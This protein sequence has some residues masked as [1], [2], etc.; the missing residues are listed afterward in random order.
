MLFL[1]GILPI[2]NILALIGVL[3]LNSLSNGQLVAGKTIGNVSDNLY[4]LFAPAG[5]TFSIWG[6]I[7]LSL[8]GFAIFQARALGKDALQ[9]QDAVGTIGF[10]FVLSSICNVVWL[11][12]WLN[13]K[14]GIALLLMLGLLVS[15]LVIYTRLNTFL[16]P[17]DP[18]VFWLVKMPFSLY[19]SWI[20]VAT[21]ANVSAWLAFN[22]W[23]GWG[24]SAYTWTILLIGIASVVGVVMTWVR[25]DPFF[26]LVNVWALF[27]IWI[28]HGNLS[29]PE[30]Q[31][32]RVVALGGMVLV[33][34]TAVAVLVTR[35][36]LIA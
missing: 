1:R 20:C 17:S 32:V 23:A 3:V 9:A 11:I 36:P 10:W 16:A 30:S 28:K 27:G 15:L 26:A 5:I 31:T 6:L 12:A 4:T 29:A 2:L 33:A 35:R 22:S 19:T 24:L 13:E 25:H 21:I 14:P 34:V 8:I 18:G 7:Y